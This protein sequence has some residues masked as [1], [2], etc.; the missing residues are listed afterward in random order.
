M[1]NGFAQAA[2]AEA[3]AIAEEHLADRENT[4]ALGYVKEGTFDFEKIEQMPPASE[5]YADAV[6]EKVEKDDEEELLSEEEKEMLIATAVR[7]RAFG[8]RSVPCIPMLCSP[9][10]TRI[11]IDAFCYEPHYSRYVI[12][13]MLLL[14]HCRM[15]RKG[16]TCHR[17]SRPLWMRP[18]RCSGM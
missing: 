5:I 6:E 11:T 2:I 14:L 18:L 4:M 15:L 13:M 3:N 12:E 16:D 8:G 1:W 9:E 17:T 10:L 7:S